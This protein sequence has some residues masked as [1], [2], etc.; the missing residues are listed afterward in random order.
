[1]RFISIFSKH[2]FYEC[3]FYMCYAG[4]D[5][6]HCIEYKGHHPNSHCLVKLFFLLY[7]EY[8]FITNYQRT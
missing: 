3:F 2:V 5:S 4:H 8:T 6:Y 1:M 7:N